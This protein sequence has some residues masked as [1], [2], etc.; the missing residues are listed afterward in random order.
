MQCKLGKYAVDGGVWLFSGTPLIVILG[1][2]ITLLFMLP[3]FCSG[4]IFDVLAWLGALVLLPIVQVLIYKYRNPRTTIYH[5][6]EYRRLRHTPQAMARRLEFTPIENISTTM[7]HAIIYGE[8]VGTFMFHR[9]FNLRGLLIATKKNELGIGLYGGSTIT[10]QTMKNCFLTHRRTMARKLVELYYTA[11]A[12]ALWSKKRIMEVYL[13]IIEFGNGIFGV[14]HACEHYFGH[15]IAQVSQREAA[16]L[17]CCLPSPKRANPNSYTEKYLQWANRIERQMEEN[18]YINLS[19][20]RRLL[21]PEL[22]KTHAQGLP[23][24]AVW[25]AN[26]YLHHG[27]EKK[28]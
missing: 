8:D 15:S 1:T 23:Y 18:E 7:I 22:M 21:D 19:T 10:Q 28:D 27:K 9:G 6:K 17:A 3:F 13:N 5:S 4:W 12:E 20:P 11:L 24:F 26:Y 25:L 16:L 2:T 14:G